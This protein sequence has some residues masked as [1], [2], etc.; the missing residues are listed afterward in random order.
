VRRIFDKILYEYE[1]SDVMTIITV[2]FIT[3]FL[4]SYNN[5]LLPLIKQFFLIPNRSN[6]FVDCRQ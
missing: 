6:E 3:H 2:S 1:S 5:R 4:S